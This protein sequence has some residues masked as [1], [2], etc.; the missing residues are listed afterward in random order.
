MQ[1]ATAKQVLW[2]VQELT[3]WGHLYYFDL[4]ERKREKEKLF[5]I[6]GESPES[7]SPLQAQ[8]QAKIKHKKVQAQ[9]VLKMRQLSSPFLFPL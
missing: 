7:F 2:K 4:V 9:I 1:E 8:E 5:L 6:K 3:Y